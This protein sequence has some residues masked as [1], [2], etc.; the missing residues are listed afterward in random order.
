MASESVVIESAYLMGQMLPTTATGV[1]IGAV[2]GRPAAG[3]FWYGAIKPDRLKEYKAAGLTDDQA[4]IASTISAAIE[5][6][7]ETVVLNPFKTKAVDITDPAKKAVSRTAYNAILSV[8]K[9]YSTELGEETF[10]AVTSEGI[11]AAASRLS[12]EAPDVPW[13]SILEQAVQQTGL[14]AIPVAAMVGPGGAVN[15]AGAAVQ[16]RAQQQRQKAMI[17]LRRDI[18]AL[19]NAAELNGGVPP[20][21]IFESIVGKKEHL[22]RLG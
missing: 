13:S 8:I 21:S 7:V 15:V 14:A 3:A 12:E 6:A 9:T 16:E 4:E 11:K 17:Q 18:D 20:R 1:A 2:G 19:D 5:A 10:Q 22:E